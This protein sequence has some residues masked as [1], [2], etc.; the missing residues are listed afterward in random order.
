MA[1]TNAQELPLLLQLQLQLLLLLP[2][3]L[4]VAHCQLMKCNSSFIFYNLFH[5]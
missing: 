4:Q 1:H 5:I 3:L 2:L